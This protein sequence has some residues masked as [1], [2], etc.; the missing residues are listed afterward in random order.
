MYI[1]IKYLCIMSLG[2]S[3]N[4]LVGMAIEAVVPTYYNQQPKDINDIIKLY[5][6]KSEASCYRLPSRNFELNN[7]TSDVRSVDISKDGNRGLICSDNKT[8]VLTVTHLQSNDRTFNDQPI[9]T[10]TS[11]RANPFLTSNGNYGVTCNGTKV[12]FWNFT[13]SPFLA[14][15]LKSEA[16]EISHTGEI[17][18]LHGTRNGEWVISG[19]SNGKIFLW[20]VLDPRD[21][22]CYDL[23]RFTRGPITSASIS[24]D[25]KVVIIGSNVISILNLNDPDN[26]GCI[27]NNSHTGPL[28]SVLISEDGKRAL[29]T[30]TADSNTP[31]IQLWER[32]NGILKPYT[33]LTTDGYAA[34]ALTPKGNCI[35]AT[36]GIRVNIWKWK[37]ESIDSVSMTSHRGHK[38]HISSAK[39]TDDGTQ[40]FT[41]SHDKTAI[42]WELCE[43]GEP[44]QNTLHHNNRVN[45]VTMSKC[46][47][48]GISGRAANEDHTPTALFWD[49]SPSI[50]LPLD[51]VINLSERE[52]ISAAS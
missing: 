18:A 8:S 25:A 32:K 51:D 19:D 39:A 13:K 4:L 34:S 7:H 47:R 12:L 31:G 49:F 37:N 5:L 50:D 10:H 48:W 43:A 15:E 1:K 20:N 6:I 30:S 38:G 17:S 14:I 26:P 45:T 24:D 44:R 27:L 41:G 23:S 29:T 22:I 52:S 36:A 46:G 33:R 42:H 3:N 2:F 16:T 28:S 21:P 35:V 40:L 11:R 9:T